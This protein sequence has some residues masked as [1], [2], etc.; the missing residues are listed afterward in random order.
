MWCFQTPQKIKLSSFH[1]QARAC[2][3][4]CVRTNTETSAFE[5]TKY[6]VVKLTGGKAQHCLLQGEFGVEFKGLGKDRLEC[7][8]SGRANFNWK[9]SAPYFPR[10]RILTSESIP[11]TGSGEVPAL[12]F[13]GCSGAKSWFWVL[14]K[15]RI[16]SSVHALASWLNR[17]TIFPENTNKKTEHLVPNRIRLV[18]AC[19][20]V[21]IL[22]YLYLIQ[23]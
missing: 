13:L 5:A 14:L 22:I 10:L 9:A 15:V 4:T 6:F 1:Y 12:W 21:T 18:W 7:R 17:F 2:R 19:S 23:F 8:S 11:V 20:A 16:L 3:P